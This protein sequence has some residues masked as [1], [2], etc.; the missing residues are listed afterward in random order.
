MAKEFS[1]IG[2]FIR[3]QPIAVLGS[4]T[5]VLLTAVG[6]WLVGLQPVAALLIVVVCVGPA[7][8]LVARQ[9]RCFTDGG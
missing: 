5:L 6:S 1:G 8:W 3:R 4:A 2:D 7:V 9:S